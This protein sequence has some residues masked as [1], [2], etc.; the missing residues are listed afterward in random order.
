MKTVKLGRSDLD[1]SRLCLGSMSWG[2]GNSPAEGHAQIDRARERGVNF[3]DT[4]EIYPTYPVRAE[5]VGRTEEII[6]DWV[7]KSGRR[8]NVVLATKVAPANP[9][10]R[11]GDG[12]HGGNIGATVDASLRRL[13]TDMIDLYQLHYPERGAYH[14]RGN[15]TYDP[16]GQDRAETAAHMLGVL[17][18]MDRV[19]R[20]GKVRFFGLSNET[21]WGMSMWI[22]LAEDNGLP[23][24]VSI[25]NEY[26]LLCRT[27]DT[28]M[29][30][31]CVNEDIAL[32][33]YSPLGMGL[34]SGKYGP[35]SMPDGSRRTREATLNGRVTPRVWSAIDAY[36]DIAR[37]HGLDHN[38]M[39]LA[40][41]LSRPFVAAPIFGASSM[42]QLETALGAA[43]LTLSQDLLAEIDAAH[44]DHPMPF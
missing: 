23:R 37:K 18:A 13:A 14:M 19:I 34:V 9:N 11:G 39:A 41:T 8:D 1:V 36:G 30:E 4:A 29:A 2:S 6:G 38:Q 27:A 22:R 26:S 28:D 10:V 25:Q 44:R 17:Q 31:L 32:L 5:T 42:E 21:V 15:W 43:D 7:R 20:A 33:P 3:I 24:P 35:D 12:F 16:S 40:F